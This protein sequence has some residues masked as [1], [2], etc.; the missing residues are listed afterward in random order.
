MK[1]IGWQ[2]ARLVT[3][4]QDDLVGGSIEQI[5]RSPDRMRLGLVIGSRRGKVYLIVG[6]RGERSACYWTRH[7]GMIQSWDEYERTEA[8]NRLRSARVV[9]VG[10]APLDRVV[11]FELE[12][13]GA[14]DSLQ[15]FSLVAAWVG[16][17]SNL[18]LVDPTT[19]SVL[20]SLHADE[21]VEGRKSGSRGKP[22][23]LPSPPDLA[24]WRGLTY[25]DF[26]K[27][28]RLESELGFADFLRRRFWGI[29]SGLARQIAE[30]VKSFEMD[31]TARE[32]DSSPND[33]EEYQALVHT[34]GMV[35]DPETAFALSDGSD[36]PG[37]I[38]LAVK[39]AAA[40]LSL[41]ESA[42]LTAIPDSQSHRL[43]M[44]SGPGSSLR[45]TPPSRRPSDDWHRS[46]ARLAESDRAEAYKKQGELLGANRS[47]LHKGLSQIE[48]D[49]WESGERVVIPL[50]PA[51]SPQQNIDDYFRKARKAADAIKA[52]TSE[53]PRLIREQE[54]LR[55]ALIRLES[56]SADPEAPADI[57]ASLGLDL[58]SSKSGQ[59]RTGPRLPYREFA[60]GKERIWVG[61]SSRDNDEL[62]LR[63]ARPH[64]IFFHVHGSPGSHVI[65]KRDS[66]D[67]GV[68]KAT[69]VQAAQAAAYFSK[70]KHAGL[71]PVVY[72]E[73]RFVRKPRKAP[74]GTVS[75]EREKSVMV[76]PLPPPG[77]H[78]KNLSS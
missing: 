5:R 42:S 43:T 24:D 18:W 41:A 10:M 59:R 4:A 68:D 72:A 32:S 63:F 45:S 6:L 70:A 55:A 13:P 8:F 77:Y 34:A 38:R 2:L 64:D 1:V 9:G 65:L 17:G 51:R 31:G 11:R 3:E 7:R 44:A 49:D 71:V 23:L 67:G 73:A 56:P 53:Q 20:E 39:D 33:W 62:T 78:D 28:R 58:A 12:K 21:D 35:M 15:Q 26:R 52:A 46:R 61:R 54:K 75:I 66:K 47:S 30:S 57:A 69:I 25:A 48:V 29:D 22:L 16:A 76:R 27:L 50:N 37:D 19:E 36:D 74:A 14:D 60:L 40:A